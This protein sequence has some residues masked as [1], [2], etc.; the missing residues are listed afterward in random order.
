MP[1]NTITDNLSGSALNNETLIIGNKSPTSSR[2]FTGVMD[3]LQIYDYEL[4]HEQVSILFNSFILGVNA[5]RANI[6]LGPRT[7]FDLI[8]QPEDNFEHFFSFDFDDAGW[9][10]QLIHVRIILSGQPHLNL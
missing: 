1:L 4:S 7:G 2:F 5:Y 10:L 3:D 8:Y 9:G 6:F